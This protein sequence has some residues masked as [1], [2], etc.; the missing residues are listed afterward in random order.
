MS[1]GGPALQPFQPSDLVALIRYQSLKLRNLRALL[2]NQLSQL[3]QG[4]VI[5]VRWGGHPDVES[6]RSA[7]GQAKS[8]RSPPVL[9]L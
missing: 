8:Y 1:A 2:R 5:G 6:N 7:S 9:P 4:K 3:G